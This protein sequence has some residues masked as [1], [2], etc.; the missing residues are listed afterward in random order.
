MCEVSTS[1]A[2]KASL[3]LNSH[4]QATQKAPGNISGKFWVDF[5]S[6]KRHRALFYQVC[7]CGRI[8]ISVPLICVTWHC[9]LL[10]SRARVWK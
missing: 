8:V 5:I 4:C 1:T 10:W 9:D 2:G 6:V 3:F 7:L